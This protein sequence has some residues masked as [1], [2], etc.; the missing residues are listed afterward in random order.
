MIAVI[1]GFLASVPMAHPGEVVD[2]SSASQLGSGAMFDAI[3][4]RYDLVN[5]ALSLGADGAW[6]NKLVNALQLEPGD[7]ILD[8]AT[9]TADVA[10]SLAQQPQ[11]PSVIGVDPSANMLDLGRQKVASASLGGQIQLNQGDA[12]KL[13]GY[14]TDSFSKTSIAFGIR[15]IPDR[16]AAL[17]E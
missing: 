11:Q 6:R 9:G 5:K 14:D 7:R 12:Q 1:I 10:I 3:A 16:P 15:N 13:E 17:R 4:H 2:K 8:L